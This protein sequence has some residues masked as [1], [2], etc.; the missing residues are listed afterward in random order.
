MLLTRNIGQAVFALFIRL[1][2][3]ITFYSFISLNNRVSD[4][5]L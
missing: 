5:F 3:A 1:Y 4:A 2:F